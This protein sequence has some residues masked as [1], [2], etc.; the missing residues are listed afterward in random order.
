LVHLD[1]L[2]DVLVRILREPFTFF[3]VKK[4]VI[5]I[6]RYLWIERGI[7]TGNVIEVTKL[8]LEFYFVVL[9]VY[10]LP[11]RIFIEFTFGTRLYLKPDDN[12]IGPTII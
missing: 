7:Y 2:Y 8:D 4:H 6:T 9:Y 5:R 12:I 3:G 11:F 1:L 10:T